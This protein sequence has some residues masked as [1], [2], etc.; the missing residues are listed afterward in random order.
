MEMFQEFTTREKRDRNG[1]M[2]KSTKKQY[3]V[4]KFVGFSIVYG[5]VLVLVIFCVCAIENANS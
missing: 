1:S 2:H 5:L 3:D 4:A